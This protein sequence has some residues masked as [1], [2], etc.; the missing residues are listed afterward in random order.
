[1]R[2]HEFGDLLLLDCDGVIL[3]SNYIK[4]DSM[5]C[6]LSDIEGIAE[7]VDEAVKYFTNNFGKSRFHH[8][9]AFLNGILSLQTEADKSCVE[10]AILTKYASNLD[11]SYKQA[12]V[13]EGFLD[14]L[15]A[16]KI[17]KYV[18]SGSEQEQLRAVFS[19]KG[20][21]SY[22]EEVFGSPINKIE[23]VS[24]ILSKENPESPVLI[25]DSIADLN[26][27]LELGIDF[28]AYTP[29]SNVAE[30]LVEEASRFGFPVLNNW[31]EVKV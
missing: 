12:M 3:N 27:A 22:F 20:L 10:R 18:V 23:L 2:F 16:L 21:T 25:G 1:M 7:G 14:F 4:I 29:Y 28:V 9:E 30:E 26:V 19:E 24:A 13:T 8:V 31:A 17:K 6:A 15:T 5:R 11:L